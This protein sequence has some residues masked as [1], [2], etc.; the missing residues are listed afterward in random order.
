MAVYLLS[1]NFVVYFVVLSYPK[2]QKLKCI[3]RKKL[4]TLHAL[5]GNH[6]DQIYFSFFSN[7][8][9]IS[10]SKATPEKNIAL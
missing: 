7:C 10:L 8:K 6:Y 5:F 3:G 2:V 1:Q 9:E 4:A